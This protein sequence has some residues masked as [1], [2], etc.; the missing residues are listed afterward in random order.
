M[1]G[2]RAIEPPQPVAAPMTE[3]I[4]PRLEPWEYAAE[5]HPFAL[6]TATTH[7]VDPRPSTPLMWLAS[8]LCLTTAP[9]ILRSKALPVSGIA[10]IGAGYVGLTTATC[11]AHPSH[12][13][14]CADIDE[15]VDALNKAVPIHSA[16]ELLRDG[17]SQETLKFVVGAR[18]AVTDSEFV[19]LP[20]EVTMDEP[21]SPRSQV[22]EDPR[23][24]PGWK[25]HLGQSTTP[26]G[27]T[28]PSSH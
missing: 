1:V 2:Y 7:K 27:T 6:N 10:V 13:V 14:I 16:P 22:I 8:G 17:L 23:H 20:P 15:K 18:Q 4:P 25:H 5:S 9:H 21:I 19:F 3:T 26:V 11:L 24:H 28:Q 12:T